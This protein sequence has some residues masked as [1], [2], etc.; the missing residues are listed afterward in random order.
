MSLRDTHVGG[1]GGGGGGG[2]E[3]TRHGRVAKL[4]LSG[5]VIRN[6]VDWWPEVEEQ[7]Q[8]IYQH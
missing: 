2:G 7:L 6:T 4:Y 3:F 1:G 5:T 8:N